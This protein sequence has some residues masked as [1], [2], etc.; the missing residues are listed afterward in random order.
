MK[1]GSAKDAFMEILDIWGSRDEHTVSRMEAQ[2]ED[3]FF[4]FGTA[5]HET[6]ITPKDVI[7]QITKEISQIPSELKFECDW[8]EEQEL[9]DTIYLVIG[10]FR[11]TGILNG[12]KFTSDLMRTSAILNRKGKKWILQHWHASSPDR[13]SDDEV[14]PGSTRPKLYED[15]TI[16]LPILWDSQTLPLRSLRR[17]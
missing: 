13:S 4:G 10:K 15:V 17:N 2:M 6:Y 16:L 9:S 12:K 3:T 5:G 11:F 14:F 7:A 8:V 1:R